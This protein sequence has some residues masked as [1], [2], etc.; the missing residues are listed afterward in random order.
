MKNTER[1][2]SNIS[3]SQSVSKRLKAMEKR[4]STMLNQPTPIITINTI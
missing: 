4:V 1:V 3:A 2:M